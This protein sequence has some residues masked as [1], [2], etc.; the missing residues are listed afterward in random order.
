MMERGTGEKVQGGVYA[1]AL[2]HVKAA[3]VELVAAIDEVM[4]R[5]MRD[6]ENVCGHETPQECQDG[7]SQESS[8]TYEE[9]KLM[10][11]FDEFE[12]AVVRLRESCRVAVHGLAQAVPRRL[13]PVY[14]V[15]ETTAEKCVKIL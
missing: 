9:Q 10:A 6:V 3:K 13:E 5:L 12:W 1:S 11:V 15:T 7:L 2:E 8:G 14:A 4:A